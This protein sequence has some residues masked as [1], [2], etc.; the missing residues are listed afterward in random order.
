MVS[1]PATDPSVQLKG[2]L[3][4]DR[5]RIEQGMQPGKAG[6]VL[7]VHENRGLTEHIK[8]VVRR[9]ATAGYVGLGVDLISR[10]GGSDAH[11]DESERT[12][13]L[14]Q[15]PPDLLVSDLLDGVR[16][17]KALPSVAPERLGAVGFCFGG[18]MVWRVATKSPDL[19]AAVPFYGPSPPLADVPNI[20]AAVLGI[21]GGNDARINAGI[22]ELENALKAAGITYEIKIYEGADHAFHN[23]TGPRYNAEAARDAWQRTLAWFEAHMG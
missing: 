18:G 7:V 23:D 9:V 3:A 5:A 17:L 20:K 19:K 22:P 1:I 8:D 14:G 16:Y 6:G 2:Y 12:G 4:Y 21:Y 11:P 13:I 15:V 10:A